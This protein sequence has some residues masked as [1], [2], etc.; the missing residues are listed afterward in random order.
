MTAHASLIVATVLL[1]A[2]HAWLIVAKFLLVGE[3]LDELVA[4][5]RLGSLDRQTERAI[6][7]ERRQ[8]A[9]TT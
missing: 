7:D 1:V 9:E 5:D 4:R 2:A 8:T 6:P 3:H